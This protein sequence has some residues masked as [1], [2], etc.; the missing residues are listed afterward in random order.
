MRARPGDPGRAH[1][2]DQREAVSPVGTDV[3]LGVAAA[4]FAAFL[5]SSAGLLAAPGGT[6]SLGSAFA[7]F[8]VCAGS[9]ERA[10]A[11]ALGLVAVALAGSGFHAAGVGAAGFLAATVGAATFAVGMDFGVTGFGAAGFLAATVGAATFAVGVDL[12][13][14]GFGAAGFLA[15]T[16]GAAT[17]VAGVDFGVTGLGA[18]GFF[19]AAL[20]V[21]AT[22]GAVDGRGLRFAAALALD[23][24]PA[25][26]VDARPG[27]LGLEARAFGL[28]FAVADFGAPAFGAP[29][30][31]GDGDDEAGAGGGTVVS[32]S[33]RSRPVPSAMNLRTTPAAGPISFF[34]KESI[35]PGLPTAP[36]IHA[37]SVRGMS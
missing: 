32:S 36:P 7:A 23:V 12:G 3:S 17:F 2:H 35:E 30:T 21:A 18:A 27:G 25:V 11:F 8:A 1:H 34:G 20:G 28:R 37:A 19:A 4:P 26:A 10:G 9:A 31:S 29:T 15:A 24:G 16:V 14:T 22:G 33:R 6:T 5:G 13:V